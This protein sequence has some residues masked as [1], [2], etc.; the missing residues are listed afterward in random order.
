MTHRCEACWNSRPVAA[1]L[2]CEEALPVNGTA[3]W[4]G[5]WKSVRL[6]EY[7]S[8]GHP[9]PCC[10]CARDFCFALKVAVLA[11]MLNPTTDTTKKSAI[12]KKRQTLRDILLLPDAINAILRNIPNR[13]RKTKSPFNQPLCLAGRTEKGAKISAGSFPVLFQV[14]FRFRC[15]RGGLPGRCISPE[16][17]RSCRD[18]RSTCRGRSLRAYAPRYS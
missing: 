8:A 18:L 1:A 15:L 7:N 3:C 13:K 6:I 16:V 5:E 12:S 9:E 11:Y 10:C 14:S 17:S 2:S 4:K